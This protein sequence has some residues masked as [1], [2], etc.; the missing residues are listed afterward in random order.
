MIVTMNIWET[1][2]GGSFLEG[3]TFIVFHIED[4]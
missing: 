2:G 4:G 3:V 1:T